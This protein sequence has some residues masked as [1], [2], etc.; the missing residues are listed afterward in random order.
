MTPDAPETPFSTLRKVVVDAR[1][2]PRWVAGLTA[3]GLGLTVAG[4]SLDLHGNVLRGLVWATCVGVVFAPS[5]TR[6][7]PSNVAP[8]RLAL[9]RA[10]VSVAVMGFAAACAHALASSSWVNR[11]MWGRLHGDE[12]AWFAAL[13]AL[14]AAPLELLECAA[15]RAE[16][17]GHRVWQRPA[18][19]GA[20]AAMIATAWCA[21]AGVQTSYLLALPDGLDRGL[22]EARRQ[23][24]ELSGPLWPDE[25]GVLGA[26]AAPWALAAFGR[27]VQ[28]PV[29]R[30][31]ALVT[32]GTATV[33]GLLADQGPAYEMRAIAA[34]GPWLSA[35]AA[36][37]SATPR[38][39]RA[40]YGG[41]TAEESPR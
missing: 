8:L 7:A 36:L 33:W 10:L 22:V 12:I 30:V 40:R 11:F 18:A 2:R 28:L 41:V 29:G 27:I 15:E 34:W 24:A 1:G 16:D 35:T 25:A 21:W 3:L 37:G 19:V 20:L 13:G 31:L 32:L 5:A 14:V 4:A 39:L 6:A 17:D 23:I 9:A 38:W 26:L